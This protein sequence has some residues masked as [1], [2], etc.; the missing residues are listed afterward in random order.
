MQ[1]QIYILFI[2]FPNNFLNCINLHKLTVALFSPS[3]LLAPV[4]EILFSPGLLITGNICAACS[5]H[6]TVLVSIIL[7]DPTSWV[8]K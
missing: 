2:Y 3:I 8:F 7:G 1:K 5:V 4:K 6:W